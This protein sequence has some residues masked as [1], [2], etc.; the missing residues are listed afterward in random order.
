[1]KQPNRTDQNTSC[2][3]LTM[4][5]HRLKCFPLDFHLLQAQFKCQLIYETSWISSPEINH[6]LPV[7]C[8][9]LKELR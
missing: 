7:I 5:S 3:E 6:F 2:S 8:R 4:V 9:T 1:M